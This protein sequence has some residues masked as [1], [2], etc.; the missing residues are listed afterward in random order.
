MR[1]HE[2]PGRTGAARRTPAMEAALELAEAWDDGIEEVEAVWQERDGASPSVLA[3]M[4]KAELRCRYQRGERPAVEEYLTR[5]PGLGLNGPLVISL[6]YEEFCLREEVGLGPSPSEFCA[7]YEAWGDSLASQLQYHR[8]LSQAAGRSEPSKLFPEPGDTF[9]RFQ[10][11]EELG[12]GGEARV[13]L[14]EDLDLGGCVRA[15]KVSPDRGEEPATMGRLNHPRIVPVLW[16]ARDEATGLRGLCM[17]YRAGRALHEVLARMEATPPAERTA[18]TLWAAIAQDGSPSTPPPGPAWEGFPLHRGYPDAVAWVGAALADAL[19]HAHQLGIQ[20]RDIKPANVLM[21]R[22]GG[23]QLLDFNLAHDPHDPRQ[24]V[25]ARRGGTL[26]YMAPEQ[27]TAFLDSRRWDEVGRSADLYA[28]GLVL[29]ELLTGRRPEAPSADL[30]LPRALQDQL[31]RRLEP[32]EGPRALNP[33]VPTQVEL[34]IRRCLSPEPTTRYGTASDLAL[35]LRRHLDGYLP[36]NAP[37]LG[38]S[39]RARAFACRNRA[40]LIAAGVAVAVGLAALPLSGDTDSSRLMREAGQFLE[41]HDYGSAADRLGRLLELNPEHAATKEKLID[42]ARKAA[43]KS[44]G[45]ERTATG[46][47]GIARG[48]LYQGWMRRA[49]E[50]G[51]RPTRRDAPIMARAASYLAIGGPTDSEMARALAEEALRLDPESWR[52]HQALGLLA[53]RRFDFLEAA[54]RYRLSFETAL[55]HPPN[56]RDFVLATLLNFGAGA[57]IQLEDYS[58]ALQRIKRTEDFLDLDGYPDQRH[59]DVTRARTLALRAHLQLIERNNLIHGE[60]DKAI[61]AAGRCRSFLDQA[62]ALNPDDPLSRDVRQKLDA[63]AP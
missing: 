55:L 30:P 29:R 27:I 16:V 1:R 26:P 14:A 38:W 4:V 36:A 39:A 32:I 24:A 48:R 54:E 41:A 42:A 31:D 62:D 56:D 7:R 21:T 11:R 52:V 18:R 46:I 28:L 60:P 37:E 45:D 22:D 15:L 58:E 9:L 61:E 63:A 35:D 20:H 59:Q 33:T 3:A 49:R 5:H 17:P 40:G 2:P 13:Y 19:D 23:P 53:G 51:Y 57:L 10:L 47:E 50:H 8:M 43:E 34:I 6:V 44:L 12:R 25:A